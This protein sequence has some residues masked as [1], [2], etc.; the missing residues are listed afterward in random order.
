MLTF[1]GLEIVCAAEYYKDKVLME[2]VASGANIHLNNQ[3]AFNLPTRL[4]AKV[5]K[6]R[7][8]YGGGAYS[9][10]HDPDFM[11]VSTSEKYWQDV[12]DAYFKKYKGIK[13]GHTRDIRQVMRTGELEIPSGRFYTF[14]PIKNKYGSGWPETTIKNY[15]IKYSGFQE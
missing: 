15:P 3:L 14:S 12:L 6:F 10:A 13:D 9:F 2:E 7:T 8:I 1:K 5:L 11:P 4:V